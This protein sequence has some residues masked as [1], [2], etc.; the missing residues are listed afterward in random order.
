MCWRELLVEAGVPWGALGSRERLATSGVGSGLRLDHALCSKGELLARALQLCSLLLE[1]SWRLREVVGDF[2]LLRAKV[3]LEGSM[4]LV[5]WLLGWIISWNASLS[6]VSLD[7]WS[8]LELLVGVMRSL[9]R[10]VHRWLWLCWHLRVL[11]CSLLDHWWS[12]RL[13][14]R[15]LL[16]WHLL[17]WGELLN[18]LLLVESLLRNDGLLLHWRLRLDDRSVVLACWTPC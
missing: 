10:L 2:L 11:W 12:H 8:L 4:L 16:S 9:S 7:D 6:E 14:T 3:I 15:R 5:D 17:H 13:E 18:W 1:T